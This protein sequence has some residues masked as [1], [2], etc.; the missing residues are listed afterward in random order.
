M[1]QISRQIKESEKMGKKK[2][3]RTEKV[4][5]RTRGLPNLMIFALASPHM[6]YR[7]PLALQLL[8]VV[9]CTLK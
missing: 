5:S 3:K 4:L 2:L 1:I 6:Q 7:V 9:V 8:K